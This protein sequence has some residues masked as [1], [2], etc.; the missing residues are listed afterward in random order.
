MKPMN[1]PDVFGKNENEKKEIATQIMFGEEVYFDNALLRKAILS[2]RKIQTL[3][4]A[5][6][7]VEEVY[8]RHA[9]TR[10]DRMIAES[11]ART[12]RPVRRREESEWFP[13]AVPGHYE[14]SP[15]TIPLLLPRCEVCGCTDCG[16]N[17]DFLSQSEWD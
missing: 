14:D 12:T 10:T 16:G 1:A 6:R 13:G 9:S 7:A 5:G 11:T 17:H 3:R 2:N 8:P 15:T 4:A